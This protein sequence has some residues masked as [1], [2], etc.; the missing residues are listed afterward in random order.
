LIE[1]IKHRLE[2]CKYRPTE[3]QE[4]LNEIDNLIKEY[5]MTD[6]EDILKEIKKNAGG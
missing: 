2:E 4:L 1:L 3:R 6:L 5:Y